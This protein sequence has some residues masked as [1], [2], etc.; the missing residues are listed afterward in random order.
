MAIKDAE[1]I[2]ALAALAPEEGQR[3]RFTRQEYHAMVDAGILDEDSRVEL[4]EG[5]IIEMSPI[6]APHSGAVNRLNA[7]LQARLGGQVIVSVQ[8]PFASGEYSEPQPDVC[9]L[10]VKSDFYSTEHPLPSDILLAIEVADT[11]L[12]YDRN[13]KMP[14]Y[15]SWG[16]AEA[17]IVNVSAGSLE[18]YR[19]PHAD[20]YRSLMKLS[21]GDAV[22]PLAFPDV[23]LDVAAILPSAEEAK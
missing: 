9:L 16:I 20:G 5:T 2:E 1:P 23:T 13:V 14:L 18:V 3:R 10:K 22:S 15:A 11:S 4:I 17:W 8:N 12:R 21:A 6:R 7:L 19:D